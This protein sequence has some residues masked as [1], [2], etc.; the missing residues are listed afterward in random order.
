M[1]SDCRGCGWSLKTTSIWPIL[2]QTSFTRDCERF[3]ADPS[4][5][6]TP[7]YALYNMVLALGCKASL[8]SSTPSAFK[9]V[10]ATASVFF[11]NAL[12]VQVDLMQQR[13][14]L[15]TVQVRFTL[16]NVVIWLTDLP[17]PRRLL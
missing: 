11:Q 12:S 1:I 13:T 5:A 17:A 7:W 9:Q 2:D 10:E 8:H 15:R 16:R 6:D 4:F 3:W 14:T